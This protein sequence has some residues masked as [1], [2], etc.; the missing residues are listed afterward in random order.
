MCLIIKII[1]FVKR[2]R[3]GQAQRRNPRQVGSIETKTTFGFQ[4]ITGA[5]NLGL[6]YGL[7]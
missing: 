5:I 4:V 3:D 6:E 7:T 2:Q 1:V